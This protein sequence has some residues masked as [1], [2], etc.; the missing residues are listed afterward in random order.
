MTETK[1]DANN[2]D[3]ETAARR[4]PQ[5]DSDYIPRGPL[6]DAMVDGI[7]R[8]VTTK[9]DADRAAE[10]KERIRAALIPVCAL[11][12]E[13]AQSHLLVSFITGPNHFGKFEVKEL[14]LMKRF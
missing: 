13:A 11:M 1:I 9:S 7:A 8:L 2:V 14:C 6:A 3:L 12:D 5:V 4:R 10:L